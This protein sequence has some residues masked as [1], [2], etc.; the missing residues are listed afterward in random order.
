M[1]VRLVGG[2]R[3]VVS[4]LLVP[5][6]RFAPS[7]SAYALEALE[8]HGAL[9]GSWLAV[10]RIG[11]CHPFNPGGYDP[12]PPGRRGRPVSVRAQGS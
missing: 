11:R 4:P 9:R 3:R 8:V 6:C 7:C 5:R 12:V 10:R 1:L 2:Y